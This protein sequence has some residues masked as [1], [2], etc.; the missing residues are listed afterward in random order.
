MRPVLSTSLF[1]AVLRA[2]HPEPR[3]GD[4]KRERGRATNKQQQHKSVSH[5]Q[6]PSQSAGCFVVHLWHS[7]ATTTKPRFCLVGGVFPL[8]LFHHHSSRR[9]VGWLLP[10]S[11]LQILATD[12][13]LSKPTSASSSP[14][15][16]GLFQNPQFSGTR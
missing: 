7:T 3:G 1:L 6:P 2:L 15:F 9:V 4:R 16:S 8:S 10:L 5:P 13:T 11:L 12:K 14:Q